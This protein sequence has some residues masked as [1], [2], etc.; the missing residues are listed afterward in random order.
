MVK[1]LPELHPV[2]IVV[3]RSVIQLAIYVVVIVVSK[4]PIDG[5]GERWPLFLRSFCGFVTFST[6]Y[7]SFQMIP[8]GDASTIVYSA[9]VYVSIFA[10][11]VLGEACGIFQVIVIFIT[12]SGA[13]L[14]S[15]PSFIFG[16]NDVVGARQLEGCLFAFVSSFATAISFVSIRKMRKIP[17][18]VVIAWFSVGSIVLGIIS[19]E[20]LYLALGQT[21]K[22][23]SEITLLEWLY[24][25]TNGVTGAL[26]QLCLTFGLKLE[27][28][29]IVSLTR[30]TNIV[31]AYFIQVL[32]LNEP[33]HWTSLLGAVIVM[34]G[35]AMSCIR[36]VV[37][38]R[39]AKAANKIIGQVQE[40][41]KSD[42]GK[43]A[44]DGDGKKHDSIFYIDGIKLLS[45]VT[46]GKSEKY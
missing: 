25:V 34:S 28:A 23:P 22:W 11:L 21:F 38:E 1:L 18:S 3:I 24:L 19:L 45:Y 9:P 37:L 2:Y 10:C 16:S 7:M 14:I 4:S 17:A 8:L 39:R 40:V 13:T 26:G 5:K 42:I 32:I 6:A 46:L 29:G 20:I 35:V 33:S 41:L 43:P 15:K 44:A 30:S 36:K 12:L 27:E 31:M